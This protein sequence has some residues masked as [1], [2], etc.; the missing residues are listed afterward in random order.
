MNDDDDYANRTCSIDIL[1]SKKK[2]TLIWPW[3]FSKHWT[4]IFQYE[5]NADL[6]HFFFFRFFVL[7]CSGQWK[8]I[9]FF[10]WKKQWW[11]VLIESIFIES[12]LVWLIGG[13]VLLFLVLFFFFDWIG[14]MD[15]WTIQIFSIH[16]NRIK[17]NQIEYND[18]YE[19]HFRFFFVVV[20]VFGFKWNWLFLIICIRAKTNDDDHHLFIFHFNSNFIWWWW[21]KKN[22]FFFH[23]NFFHLSGCLSLR[24][25]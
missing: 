4:L 12:N 5:S 20:F 15:G 25:I 19:F 8:K 21:W 24:L 6:L 14:W 1:E 23:L 18:G 22:W 10:T 17:S 7:F 3:W 11:K 16:F 2:N 9:F 13:C